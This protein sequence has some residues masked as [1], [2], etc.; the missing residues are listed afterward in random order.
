MIL[1]CLNDEMTSVEAIYLAMDRERTYEE[2]DD[3]TEDEWERRAT[4]LQKITVLLY[5]LAV[6]VATLMH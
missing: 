2:G 5:I 6:N 4:V 3:T 1:K